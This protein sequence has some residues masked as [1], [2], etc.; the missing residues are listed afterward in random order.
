[1]ATFPRIH[2]EHEVMLRLADLVVAEAAAFGAGK[3]GDLAL[4]HDVLQYLTEYPKTLPPPAAR[5]GALAP[6]RSRVH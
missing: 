1:M 6:C 3:R 4:M 5:R 2:R